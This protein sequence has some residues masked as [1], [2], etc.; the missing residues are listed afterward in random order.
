MPRLA[1]GISLAGL[2]RRTIDYWLDK[3][4]RRDDRGRADGRGHRLLGLRE[5]SRRQRLAADRR[6]GLC[7]NDGRP[8]N[9]QTGWLAWWKSRD[10]KLHDFASPTLNGLAIEYGLVGPEAERAILDRLWSKISAAG[11]LDSALVFP[12][13]YSCPL[14]RLPPAGRSRPAHEGRS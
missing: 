1:G 7:R 13:C 14:R 6:L 12:P 4:M 3:R 10:G 5:F 8:V 9:P 11:A 2:V